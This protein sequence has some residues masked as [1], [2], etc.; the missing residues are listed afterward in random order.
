MDLQAVHGILQVGL[1]LLVFEEAQIIS[2]QVE[3]D[4]TN[5]KIIRAIFVPSFLQI[6]KS[7][8]HLIG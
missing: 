3:A 5:T 4:G 7:F 2:W 8:D 1:K 6:P